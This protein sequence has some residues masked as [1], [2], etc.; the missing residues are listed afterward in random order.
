MGDNSKVSALADYSVVI[1]GEKYSMVDIPKGD[2]KIVL[3]EK[4]RVLRNIDLKTLVVGLNRTKDLLYLAYNGVAGFGPLTAAMTKLQDKYG[5]LCG[6]SEIEL[7]NFERQSAQV[8]A[9]LKLVFTFLVKLKEPQAL[10]FLSQCGTVASDMAKRAMDLSKSFEELGNDAVK[11]LSDTQIQQGLEENRKKEVQGKMNE[12]DAK[13]AKAKV[14]VESLAKQ[15]D[16]L[17]KLY[18][19]AKDKAESAEN[20]GFALALVGAIM[21]PIGEGVGVFA[22]I[23]SGG[24]AAGAANN[25]AGKLS[26]QPPKL[27]KAKKTKAQAEKESDDAKKAEEDAV[28]LSTKTEQEYQKQKAKLDKLAEEMKEKADTL[29]EAKKKAKAESDKKK[30]SSLEAAVQTAEAELK[31][32]KEAHA[33]QE[34]VTDK[35]KKEADEAAKKVEIQ[36][37]LVTAAGKA[38]ADAGENVSRLGDNYLAIADNYQ[39]EKIKYLD[40]LLEKEDMERDALADIAEFAVKMKNMGGEVQSVEL[41]INSLFSAI[42]ALKQV[43]VTLRL[44]S[45]FWD[46]MA[47]SCKN[48]ANGDLKDAIEAFSTLAEEERLAYFTGDDFKAQV[49]TFFAAWKSI[50]VVCQEYAKEVNGIMLGV[51]E[52]FKQNLPL[53]QARALAIQ[54]GGV[55]LKDVEA[56]R[57]ANSAEHTTLT[58]AINEA[59][60]ELPKAA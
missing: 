38:L 6:K 54:L 10:T 57:A 60:A 21:K 29:K 43:A 32:A 4:S 5:L 15:K 41:S 11:V 25:L 26:N 9:K 34:Q 35:A 45:H 39:K 31:V 55:V 58:E 8:Q 42:G 16:K 37:A 14:L 1:D 59:K 36:K 46:N 24:A 19:E 22:A 50:E 48:L 7:G 28:S 27:P 47:A 53:D 49:V 12:L 56:G 3:A 30:K 40:L 2:S 51:H 33:T 18:A 52:N 17:Q 13:T 44:A 20:R 23:Y